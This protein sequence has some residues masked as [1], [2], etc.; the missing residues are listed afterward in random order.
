MWWLVDCVG[1]VWVSGGRGPEKL[2]VF[3]CVLTCFIVLQKEERREE[4]GEG[5]GTHSPGAPPLWGATATRKD[6]FIFTPTV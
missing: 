2:S 4:R 3:F 1:D 6:L 5:K